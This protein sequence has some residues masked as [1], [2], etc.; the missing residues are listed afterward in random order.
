MEIKRGKIR[1][2]A[3]R[4]TLEQ[5]LTYSKSRRMVTYKRYCYLII[6]EGIIICLEGMVTAV[7]IAAALAADL[8][9]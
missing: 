5:R 8:F 3:G 2:W 9:G 4:V 7:L 6:E 1:D